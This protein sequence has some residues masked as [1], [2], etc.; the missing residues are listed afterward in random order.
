MAT[1]SASRSI[2]LRVERDAG[3]VVLLAQPAGSRAQ[4]E[5]AAREHVEGGGLLGE[6]HRVAEVG[7]SGR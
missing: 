6:H 1:A 5:A 3:L 4:L 7:R 2:R